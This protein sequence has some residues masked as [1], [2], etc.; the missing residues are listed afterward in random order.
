MRLLV[1]V[2]ISNKYRTL[3]LW[4]FWAPPTYLVYSS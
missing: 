3:L 4:L 2:K 1:N